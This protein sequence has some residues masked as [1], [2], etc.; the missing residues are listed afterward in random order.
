MKG[1]DKIKTIRRSTMSSVHILVILMLLLLVT[2]LVV[3][4]YLISKHYDRHAATAA[5]AAYKKTEKDD[6]SPKVN[7]TLPSSDSNS[8]STMRR[9]RIAYIFAGALRTFTCPWSLPDG[10][11][12]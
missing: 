7:V 11:D 12:S 5:A 9:P 3:D 8:N 10:L 6:Y 4:V 1:A 2:L